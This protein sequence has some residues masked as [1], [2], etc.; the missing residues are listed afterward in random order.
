MTY[1]PIEVPNGKY[2]FVGSVPVE[3]VFEKENGEPLSE[4]EKKE[5]CTA[6]IPELV[7]KKN[8]I[9]K[10]IFE[11]LEEAEKASEELEQSLQYQED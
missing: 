4:Q 2:E 6:N 3:L 7:M 8:G 11:T 9:K 10:R 1:Q 5:L